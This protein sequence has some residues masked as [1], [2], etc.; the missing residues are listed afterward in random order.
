MFTKT[1]ETGTDTRTSKHTIEVVLDNDRY[2]VKTTTTI[3]RHTNPKVVGRVI[4]SVFPT[5]YKT[6]R[7]ATK[8][9]N[10]LLSTY[11]DRMKN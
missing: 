2:I 1:F 11:E 7:G 8:C 9:A 6:E 3:L 4:N 5:K 10:D